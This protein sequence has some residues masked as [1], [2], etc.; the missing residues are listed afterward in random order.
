[1]AGKGVQRREVEM[2]D[3]GRKK[4]EV[5]GFQGHLE[6]KSAVLQRLT[7]VWILPAP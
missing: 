7:C 3:K 5:S 1:M 4:E 2:E 6:S